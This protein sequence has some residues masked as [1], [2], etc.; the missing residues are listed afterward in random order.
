MSDAKLQPWMPE[1]CAVR[2]HTGDG[3]SAGRCFY[4]VE[5]GRCHRHGDVKAVQERFVRTGEL[6]NDYDVALASR[7]A[8][9]R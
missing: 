4:Y 6:T 5:D 1:N 9:K 7:G 8:E 2:E 3:R